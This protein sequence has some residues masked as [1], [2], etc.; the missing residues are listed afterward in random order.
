MA[1]LQT[2]RRLPAISARLAGGPGAKT[3]LAGQRWPCPCTLP[4]CLGR[5][6]P[7]GQRSC[8]LPAGCGQPAMLLAA[9]SRKGHLS[10]AWPPRK[11]GALGSLSASPLTPP[12]SAS[13]AW[14]WLYADFH[15]APPR[16]SGPG[17]GRGRGEKEE[18][19]NGKVE[20]SR[21]CQGGQSSV[22]TLF[23]NTQNY[24]ERTPR[25]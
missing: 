8:R 5:A 2:D 23:S 24:Q 10:A 13:C 22:V 16:N 25:P 21:G 1:G 14:S 11:V 3:A 15:P 18:V 17:Q 20:S 6:W 9:V 19:A 4:G 12:E 7:R